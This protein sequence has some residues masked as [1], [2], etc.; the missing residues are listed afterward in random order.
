MGAYHSKSAEADQPRPRACA[1]E[2]NMDSG[3][4]REYRSDVSDCKSCPHC[5]RKAEDAIDSNWFPLNRCNKRHELFC[6]ECGGNEEV[7]RECGSDD[8][9]QSVHK[10]YA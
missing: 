6:H 10:V 7:C 3:L 2:L 9:Q 1:F 5:S 4:S 8:T